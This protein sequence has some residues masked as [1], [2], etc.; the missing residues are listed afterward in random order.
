MYRLFLLGCMGVLCASC[1]GTTDSQGPESRATE[2]EVTAHAFR[3]ANT[4]T[5]FVG[6]AACFDCHEDEYRGFQE[7]GM[8]QSF[9]PLTPQHVVEDFSG[10]TLHHAASGYYYRPYREG[11]RFFQEEYRLGAGGQKT[12]QLV[13]EITYVVGSGTAARTYLAENNGRLY[14]MPLTWYTQAERWDFSPGYA[15]HN[16]RFDRLVPDRCMACHNSYPESVPFVEGKYTEVPHGIGCERCHGPGALHVEERLVSPEAA[17]EIDYT[18]VNPAHLDLDR[19]LDVCQQCHLQTAISVLREGR[20]PF[21]FR[22]SQSL[23]DYVALFSVEQPDADTRIPVISHAERMKESACFIASRAAGRVMDCTTC[24]DPHEGFRTK[25]ASYFN[26]TCMEC[27]AAA[28]LQMQFQDPAA[29]NRHTADANC[30]ACHMPKVEAVEAPHS[31]FTD[32]KIRVVETV[33]EPPP[34]A[35][36]APVELKP[37]FETERRAPEDP[38]YEGIAYV[39]YANQNGDSLALRQGVR[40]LEDALADRPEHG[41]AQFLLGFAHLQRGEPGAAIPPLEASVRADAG[42]PERLNALAQAYEAER[43]D[44]ARIAGLYERALAIQPSLAEVRL[45]YGRFLESQGRLDEALAQYRQAVAE[46]PWLAK[47]HYN[48]GT[49]LLRRQ[50]FEEAEGALQQALT[51]EPDDPETLGNLGLLYAMQDRPDLAREQFERAVAAAP[52]HPVALGNLGAFYLNQGD[53]A[54]AIPLLLRAVEANP[55]YVDALANLA[56][57]YLQSDQPP[58][59]RHYAREA[60]RVDPGHALA[61]QIMAAL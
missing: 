38:I 39:V 8:A 3:N 40:I 9:Y 22:P 49:A 42:I 37:Y 6:D 44:P 11:D 46:R 34:L 33:P 5:S 47:A 41:E 45:N 57:A 58:Q 52:D 16:S 31:D 10:V 48:L 28:D 51:L 60:L 29:R 56:L 25:G 21:D 43:R 12:H 59:A 4:S 27:H 54:G 61:R 19:R 32:H 1:L 23:V 13:R 53:P 30:I 15:E 50:A 55:R 2:T 7:H 35:S 17:G 24:H 18:I 36:H 14:E 20:T 26:D